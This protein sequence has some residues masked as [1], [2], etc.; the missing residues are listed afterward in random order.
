MPQLTLN[1]FNALKDS[2]EQISLRYRKTESETKPYSGV[3]VEV[4]TSKQGK[5][6]I[7]LELSENGGFRTLHVDKILVID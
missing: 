3:V 4:D 2:Q 5:P 6:F 7:K 1:R